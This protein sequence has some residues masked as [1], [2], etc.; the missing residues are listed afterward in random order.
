MFRFR[1]PHI[2]KIILLLIYYFYLLFEMWDVPMYFFLNSSHEYSKGKG[3]IVRRTCLIAFLIW[4]V[5]SIYFTRT[6]MNLTFVNDID[7]LYAPDLRL[8][9]SLTWIF[10]PAVLDTGMRNRP[11]IVYL[12]RHFTYKNLEYRRRPFDYRRGRVWMINCM[13]RVRVNENRA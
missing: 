1:S 9:R 4:H 8:W 2:E 12:T 5:F 3:M 6:F 7:F 10:H 11:P 13:C